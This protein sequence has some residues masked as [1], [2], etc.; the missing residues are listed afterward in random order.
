MNSSHIARRPA[1]VAAAALSAGAL[2]AV[3]WLAPAAP[4][5]PKAP[6]PGGWV[7]DDNGATGITDVAG[8]RFAAAGRPHGDGPLLRALIRKWGTPASTKAFGRVG[9]RVTWRTPRV[10]VTVANFGRLPRG[11]T[12]CNPRRGKLQEIRTLGR[13]WRMQ[14]GLRVGQSRARVRAMYPR[15]APAVDGDP[16]V[17]MLKPRLYPCTGC[18]GPEDLAASRRGAVNAVVPGARVQRFTVWVGAAGD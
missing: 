7:V 14:E 2:G 16:G 4:A 8:F 11:V 5:A 12:A 15:A 9:C 10:Q 3:L 6:P 17:L 18:S 13:S 1:R